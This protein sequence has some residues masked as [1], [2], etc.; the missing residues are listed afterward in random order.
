M[1]SE[2]EGDSVPFPIFFSSFLSDKIATKMDFKYS[3]IIL[4]KNDIGETDRFYHIYTLEAGK[5]RAK[6]I[7]VKKPNA[8]L[9]GNLEPIT[10]AEIFMARGRG[11]GNIT[12]VIPLNNFLAIKS[13]FSALQRVFFIF[14][15]FGRLITEEEKDEKIFKLLLEYLETIEKLAGF[16]EKV[17]LEIITLG[18]LFKFMEALGY[19][20]EVDKCVKCGK[21]LVLEKN[22][23][24]SE[25]GGVLCEKCSEKR[26]K[27]MGISN[28]SIK[29]IRIFSSNRIN[30]FLKIAAGKK[31]L[32]NLQIVAN[33]MIGWVTG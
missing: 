31:D 30:N 24:S 1:N 15:I 33:E 19:R 18:F 22:Y 28:E 32:D 16:S 11:R 14:R 29:L 7:G 25:F 23:F 13:D 26:Q 21:K 6:A 27:K 10:H 17:K 12:G 3:G 8:K 20:I 2:R 4:S 5:I 9:A